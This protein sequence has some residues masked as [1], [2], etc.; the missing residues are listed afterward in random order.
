MAQYAARALGEFMAEEAELRAGLEARDMANGMR[1]DFKMWE[2]VGDDD[3]QCR[4]CKTTCYL[5]ALT[6]SCDPKV[7]LTPRP[8]GPRAASF[9]L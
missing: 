6:C 2:L 4:A 7:R 9:P 1:R 5:S 3:R 8:P